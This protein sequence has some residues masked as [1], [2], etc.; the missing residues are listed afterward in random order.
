MR[1]KVA[2]KARSGKTEV[3]ILVGWNL[4]YVMMDLAKGTNSCLRK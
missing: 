4:T 2:R 1:E 3:K